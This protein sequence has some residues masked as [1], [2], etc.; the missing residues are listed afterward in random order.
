MFAFA[1]ITMGLLALCNLAALL[2]LYKVAMRIL[3]D[4]DTQAASGVEPKLDVEAFDDLALD[5]DAW[6]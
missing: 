5:K 2:M 4:Y 3:R 1:D 6:K